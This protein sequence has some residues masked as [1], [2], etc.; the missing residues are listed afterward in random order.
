MGVSY[1]LRCKK[2]YETQEALYELEKWDLAE[3]IDADFYLGWRAVSPD[4]LIVWV[5]EHKEHGE[6]EFTAE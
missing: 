5:T 1:F 4:K 2:C 6:I 3:N